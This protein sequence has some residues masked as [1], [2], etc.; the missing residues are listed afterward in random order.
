MVIVVDTDVSI[1]FPEQVWSV[2]SRLH[3]L[4]SIAIAQLHSCQTPC[5]FMIFIGKK[6]FEITKALKPLEVEGLGPCDAGF[7]IFIERSLPIVVA[8]KVRF[9]KSYQVKPFKIHKHSERFLPQYKD[10]AFVGYLTKA[11]LLK[12]CFAIGALVLIL[13]SYI[14]SRTV[15]TGSNKW[16]QWGQ[17][18]HE[19]VTEFC[20]T[21]GILHSKSY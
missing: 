17:K 1:F 19:V 12:C 2:L 15:F 13:I 16:M 8:L 3:T 11:Q 5:I 14:F 20:P 21:V 7:P 4:R 18:F 10:D 9:L 6:S